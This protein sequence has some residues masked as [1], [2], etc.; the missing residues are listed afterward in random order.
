M[1]VPDIAAGQ[2]V[3]VHLHA[4]CFAPGAFRLSDYFVSWTYPELENLAGSL[5][6][7]VS[8]FVVQQQSV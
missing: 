8:A 5:A 7:P 6:G 1:N 2:C 3:E 4:V